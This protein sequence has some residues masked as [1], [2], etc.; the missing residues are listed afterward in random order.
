MDLSLKPA[1]LDTHAPHQSSPF[2]LA[3]DSN[4]QWPKTLGIAVDVWMYILILIYTFANFLYLNSVFLFRSCI[5]SF[6]VLV[7]DFSVFPFHLIFSVCESKNCD[8]SVCQCC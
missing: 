8:T 2:V 6:L 5:V 4:E 7:N 3:L 1:L